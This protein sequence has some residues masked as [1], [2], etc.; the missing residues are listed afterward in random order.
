MQKS[1]SLSGVLQSR[2]GKPVIFFV[3]RDTHEF[4]FVTDEVYNP[5]KTNAAFYLE[6]KDGFAF[7]KTHDGHNAAVYIGQENF[8]VIGRQRMFLPAY[9]IS[10]SNVQP[11]DIT[12]FRGIRFIGS[13]L[14]LVFPTEVVR[15]YDENNQLTI[16]QK[17]KFISYKI[18]TNKYAMELIITAPDHEKTGL[19]G[20]PLSNTDVMLDLLFDE[21]QPLFS[22]FDHYNR[23]KEILS[24]MTFRFNVGFQGIQFIER[25]PE[26]GYIAKIADVYILDDAELTAK[27]ERDNISF[28]DLDG[29]LPNLF[30]MFY[31]TEDKKPSYSLGFYPEKDDDRRRMTNGMIREICSGIECELS[32]ISVL[33]GTNNDLLEKLIARVKGEVKSF[34]RENDGLSNDT[35]N[36]IFSSMGNWSFTLA[37]KTIELFQLYS[38]EMQEISK[39]FTRVYNAQIRSFVKYRNDIT[40]GKHRVLDYN[41]A[42]TAHVLAGL[43]YCCILS[44]IGLPREKILELCK[45]GKV[46]S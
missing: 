14:N 7:G 24:F 35:Y 16:T 32:Y 25:S 43:V 20:L 8:L 3:N 33:N 41:I 5:T 26:H 37:E 27:D 29:V 46:V 40:H 42:T 44:R 21:P 12:M 17:D 11:Q 4:S 38:D 23:V 13:T 34:R 28:H 1:N 2:E 10:S 15:F 22:L 31:D 19:D 39:G 36:M 45:D 9:I 18:S 30:K 6:P